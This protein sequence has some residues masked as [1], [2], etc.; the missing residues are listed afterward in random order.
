MFNMRRRIVITG[1]G[2]RVSNAK[3][4]EGFISSIRGMVPGQSEITLFDTSNLRTNIACQIQDELKYQEDCYERTTKIAFEAIDDFLG[5]DGVAEVIKRHKDEIVLSYSTSLSGNESMMKYIHQ[6]KNDENADT[7]HIYNIPNFINQLSARLGVSGPTYTTMSACAAGTA[8]A[9]IAIDEIRDGSANVAIVG[10]ADALTEFSSVGFHSLKSLAPGECRPFDIDRQGI[11][12]GEA[13]AFFLFEELEHALARNA[14]IYAEVLGYCS[15][16]EAYHMTSPHP[17]GD[18][19]Y[20]V[21]K[22]A[23]ADAGLSIKDD[24]VYINAHGTG[25]KANDEMEF[26][27]IKRLFGDCPNVYV[28]STKSIT[29]HCLGAAGSIELAVVIA[30]LSNGFIPGTAHTDDILEQHDNIKIV[31]GSSPEVDIEYAISNS[32]AFAGNTSSII[33][34]KYEGK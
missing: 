6:T 16:N 24:M 13:S 5:K 7:S 15:K 30:A 25:T 29:G 10:G 11:N 27:A 8:A 9:G 28:S 20:V 1:V 26:K 34:K 4:Y 32:F 33:L 2:V 14:K 3:N 22:D 18:G 12:L 19:A 31:A 23:L 17:E 21:M